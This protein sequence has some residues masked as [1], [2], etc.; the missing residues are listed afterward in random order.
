MSVKTSAPTALKGSLWGIWQRCFGI[1]HRW[2]PWFRVGGLFANADRNP[3]KAREC[4]QVSTVT[5]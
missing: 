4:C 3:Q 5:L 1:A 2:N